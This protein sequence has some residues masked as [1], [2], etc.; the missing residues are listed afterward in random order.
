MNGQVLAVN[1]EQFNVNDDS[2]KITD[3]LAKPGQAVKKGELVMVLDS[4]KASYDIHT[5]QEGIFY[6]AFNPGDFVGVNEAMYLMLGTFET[7][8]QL[9]YDA[10]FTKAVASGNGNAGSAVTGD[11]TITQK[12]KAL[13]DQHGLAPDQLGN[14]EVITEKMVQA[15][16]A[17]SGTAS[18]QTS[19]EL[20]GAHYKVIKKLAVLGAGQAFIQML[21]IM[22]SNLYICTA[23][24]DD[25]AAFHGNRIYGCEVKGAID[26]VQLK[27]DHAAG[28]FDELIIS[29][30]GS[31]KVRKL[32]YDRL[33][34]LNIPFANL[35]HPTAHIGHHCII[36][37][38]NVI[39]P[40]VHIG[41]CA[42]IGDNNLVSAHCN[43][44]HHN[45][46]GSHCTFGPGV[47]MSGTVS[48]GDQVKFGT[49]IFIEPGVKIG[50]QSIVSSGC[51]VTKHI[52]EKHIAFMKAGELKF[53]ENQ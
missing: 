51:I 37:S 41:P 21:D 29:I 49:G 15:Y 2:Y 31:T 33:Q 44:E 52:P 6:T 39:L 32:I 46:L 36:G 22:P 30:G 3:V 53:K 14:P 1:C 35:I 50:N 25:N 8:K 16:L 11:R 17:A 12:A 34:P 5:E 13:M 7:D 40:F 9:E 27:N 20:S 24:Y 10:F 48:I 28:L 18:K 26:P 4:S 47:M 42:R 19:L 38:G 23:I 45:A 43:I